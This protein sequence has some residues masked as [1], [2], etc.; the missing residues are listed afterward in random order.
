MRF[1][2]AAVAAVVVCAG[3]LSAVEPG[4]ALDVLAPP[5]IAGRP[6][7]AKALALAKTAKRSERTRVMANMPGRT[8]GNHGGE[9]AG[10]STSEWTKGP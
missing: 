8:S 6:K 2:D 7:A 5:K 9:G 4:S 1:S 10:K 3:V